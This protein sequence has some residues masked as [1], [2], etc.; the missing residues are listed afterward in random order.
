[1]KTTRILIADDHE[2]FRRGVAA[3]LTQ[4]PG[5]VVAAEATNGRDAVALA[6]S[7]R[8]DIVVLDLTMPELNGLEAARQIVLA[9]PSARILI[10]TAHESEQ[11]VREV[12]SAG[13][14]GYVLKSDAG[15]TL[16]TAL[17]ALLEGGSFFTSN[18]ARMVLDGYLRSESS[19]AMPAQTLSAREREIVQLLAEGN[20]NKDIARV[21]DISVKTAETHRSNI[22]R[23]MEFDSLAELVRYAIR[24]NIIDP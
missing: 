13:A 17:Q 24:N 16:I 4:V 2:L 23:K 6:A 1:M 20:S 21:L 12:L 10:L 22:M 19:E 15:R 14:Q 9:D 11:L 5:W 8:P 3:E 18:V 7:L